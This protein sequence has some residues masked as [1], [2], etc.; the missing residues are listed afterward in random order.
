MTFQPGGRFS[1]DVEFRHDVFDR[2]GTRGRVYTVNV[3]NTRTT[4]QFSKEFAVRG[5]VQYD[6]QKNRVLTDFLGSYDL[7]PGTVVYVGYG[8][9]Y[10]KRAYQDPDWIEGRGRYLAT[11]RGLFLKA[12]YLY[13]F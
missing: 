10:E 1:E 2:P 11:R 5:I 9:L 12:S 6:S 8:S 3:V 13:R 7:R 4:Y